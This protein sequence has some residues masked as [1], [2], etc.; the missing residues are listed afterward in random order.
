MK[1]MTIWVS[2][3]CG[4]VF[5]FQNVYDV[6]CNIEEWWHAN[7]IDKVVGSNKSSC[8][9]G[10]FNGEITRIETPADGWKL[11]IALLKPELLL[12]KSEEDK[13]VKMPPDGSDAAEKHEREQ[14]GKQLR[15]EYPEFSETAIWVAGVGH[16]LS[17]L[18][19]C[20]SAASS[21]P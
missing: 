17:D 4:Q 9:W 14:K 6:G 18:G 15:Y 11:H 21:A 13:Y 16:S 20:P 3:P 1:T 2:N 5:I 10:E 12:R 19:Q 7:N 8:D